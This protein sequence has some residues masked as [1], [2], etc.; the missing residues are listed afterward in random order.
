[1]TRE[2]NGRHVSGALFLSELIGRALLVF[3]SDHDRLF[4]RMARPRKP[5]QGRSID[6]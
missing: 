2:S 3:D 6:S 1:M 4:R 5:R